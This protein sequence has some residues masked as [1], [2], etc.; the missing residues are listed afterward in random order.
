MSLPQRYSAT[1]G[2]Q[3]PIAHPFSS[4]SRSPRTHGTGAAHKAFPR[5]LHIHQS[6]GCHPPVSTLI[7]FIQ[8]SW[9]PGWHMTL[10]QSFSTSTSLQPVDNTFP[11]VLTKTHQGLNVLLVKHETSNTALHNC[12]AAAAQIPVSRSIVFIN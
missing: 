8:G 5:V 9:Y 6:A 11:I 10:S 1:A 7:T 12:Q 3:R 4:S 2:L